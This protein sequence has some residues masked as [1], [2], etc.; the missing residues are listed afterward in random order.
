MPV[1]INKK[2][3]FVNEVIKLYLQGSNNNKLIAAIY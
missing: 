3:G 2:I 1:L